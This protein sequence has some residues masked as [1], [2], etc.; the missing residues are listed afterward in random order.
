MPT[1]KGGGN[2][3]RNPEPQR[4]T[5]RRDSDTGRFVTPAYTERHPATTETQH[6]L[7][8]APARQTKP[9]TPPKP[10]SPKHPKKG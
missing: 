6:P 5:V 4:T 7:R 9:V 2:K 3:P 1:G 10:P 8:G